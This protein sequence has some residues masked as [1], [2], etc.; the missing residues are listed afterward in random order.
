[1]DA[2]IGKKTLFGGDSSQIDLSGCLAVWLVLTSSSR[3]S[4]PPT[5]GIMVCNHGTWFALLCLGMLCCP[6][7]P[8]Q[9]YKKVRVDW[10][11]RAGMRR[12]HFELALQH[13]MRIDGPSRDTCEGRIRCVDDRRQKSTS[14]WFYANNMSKGDF[15]RGILLGKSVVSRLFSLFYS[16]RLRFTFTFCLAFGGEHGK[17]AFFEEWDCRAKPPE[18]SQRWPRSTRSSKEAYLGM[19]LT[20]F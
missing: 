17:E 7:V 6:P 12:D 14:Y 3:R 1:M 2:C 15:S 11:A 16:L 5:R 4:H 13:Y 9:D 19:K 8:L 18:F 10:R 20:W